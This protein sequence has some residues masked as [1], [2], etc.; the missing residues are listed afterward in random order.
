MKGRLT[1][2]RT[3]R[4]F[5]ICRH[6][7]T[8]PFGQ[9]M[10]HSIKTAPLFTN[11]GLDLSGLLYLKDSAEEV[12]ICLFTCAVTR[13]VHLKLLCSMTIERFLF[14]FSS[15]FLLE[16]TRYF[17]SLIRGALCVN[18]APGDKW[19]RTRLGGKDDTWSCS[20]LLLAQY[21]TVTIGTV[22]K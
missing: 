6:Y 18:L 19:V 21:S 7:R 15:P 11:L 16:K 9:Q 20:Q 1:V 10:T 14:D 12:Y 22:S 2:R 4:N 13:A 3:Q 17:P 8:K 5:L